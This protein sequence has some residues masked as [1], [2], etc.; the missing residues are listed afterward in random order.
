ML[1]YLA[2]I[3]YSLVIWVIAQRIKPSLRNKIILV[4]LFII[5]FIIVCSFKS[6]NVGI[7]SHDYY[8][9]YTNINEITFSYLERAFVFYNKIFRKLHFPYTGFLLVTYTIAFVPLAVLAL[10]RTERP[11]TFLLF[12]MYLGYFGFAMSA[13]RQPLAIGIALIGYCFFNKKKILTAIFPIVTCA[14]AF[15]FHKS[16]MI[17]LLFVVVPYIKISKKAFMY[18]ILSVLILGA[19]SIPAYCLIFEVF[20]RNNVYAPMIS[21]SAVILSIFVSL[22]ALSYILRQDFYTKFEEEKMS[23]FDDS[24]F[25]IFFKNTNFKSSFEKKDEDYGDFLYFFVIIVVLIFGITNQV[26]TRMMYDCFPFFTLAM[27]RIFDKLKTKTSKTILSIAMV[28]FVIA[29][30][31]FAVLIKDPLQIVPYSIG[32]YL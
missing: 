19:I 28:F 8:R 30:F 4:S 17:L 27:F 25:I 2:L 20:L 24:K 13:M 5:P 31:G 23:R 16:S 14:I 21:N 29:Y 15:L 6:T 3:F 10:K 26:V 22:T 11:I 9:W 7:D 32:I 18:L 12:V 1:V